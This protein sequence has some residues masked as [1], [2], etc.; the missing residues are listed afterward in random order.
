MGSPFAD[1]MWLSWLNSVIDY[2]RLRSKAYDLTQRLRPVPYRP[3]RGP[4]TYKTVIFDTPSKR[5]FFRKMEYGP[6]TLT[7][8]ILFQNRISGL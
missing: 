4:G 7:G 6:Q 2:A 1:E 5:D 3:Q 8:S